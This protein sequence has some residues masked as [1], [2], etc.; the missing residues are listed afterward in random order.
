MTSL[1]SISSLRDYHP[2]KE[3]HPIESGEARDDDERIQQ[4]SAPQLPIATT[5]RRSF[6]SMPRQLDQR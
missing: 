3:I 4:R 6:S 1:S 2:I 5:N